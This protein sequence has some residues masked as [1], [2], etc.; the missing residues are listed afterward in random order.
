M[1]AATT[2]SSSPDMDAPWRWMAAGWRDLWRN[3]VLS[4]GYGAVFVAAG[5]AVTYGLW[6]IGMSALILPVAACFALFGPLLAV[7]LYEMSRRYETGEPIRL[8][9]IVFVK[10]AAPSQLML[11]SFFLMFAMLVWIRIATL[12]FAL[13]VQGP[14]PSLTELASF[15]LTDPSGLAMIFVGTAVGAVIAFV[16]FAISAVSIPMLMHRDVDAVTAIITSVDAVR[17]RPGPM[18]LWAWLIAITVAVGSALAL[19]GLVVAFPLLGH[20]TWRAYREIV[21]GEKAQ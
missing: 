18:L 3:P 11:V 5:L 1:M 9:D 20:A 15:V 14:P 17:K 4:L 12:L 19:V 13:F 8:K 16:I 6:R 10:T 7:G 21:D 2:A